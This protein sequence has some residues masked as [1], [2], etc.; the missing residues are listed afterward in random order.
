MKLIRWGNLIMTHKEKKLS[1]INK[2]CNSCDRSCKQY[3]DVQ[4]LN[5]PNYVFKPCQQ[6]LPFW[7]IIREK[8]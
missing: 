1:R 3:D 7:K 4:L 5:C 8:K 6:Y 2:L